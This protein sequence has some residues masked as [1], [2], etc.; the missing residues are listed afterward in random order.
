MTWIFF[1]L[2]LAFFGVPEFRWALELAFFD[3]RLTHATDKDFSAVIT[4]L[5][6]WSVPQNELR[7]LAHRAEQNR[8]AKALAFAALHLEG[9]NEAFRAADHAVKI[10]SSLYWIGAYLIPRHLDNANEAGIAA[11]I[12]IWLDRLQEFAPDNGYVYFVR[13]TYIRKQDKDFPRHITPTNVASLADKGLYLEV[14]HG[15]FTR[16]HFNDYWAQVLLLQRDVLRQEGW[17]RP[18]TFLAQHMGVPIPD[19]LHIRHYANYKVFYLASKAADERRLDDAMRE[20]HETS[21]FGQ[22]MRLEGAMLIIRLIGDATEMIAS[23]PWAESLRKAGRTKEATM[24]EQRALQHRADHLRW[25]AARRAEH[26]NHWWIRLTTRI[27]ALAVAIF[28]ALSVL[29]VFLVNLC[30]WMRPQKWGAVYQI[31][32]IGENYLCVLFFVSCVSLLVVY[33]PYASNFNYY[34]TAGDLSTGEF[35][36]PSIFPLSAAFLLETEAPPP[37]L[38]FY[39]YILWAGGGLGVLGLAGLVSA[40]R[41]RRAS[42]NQQP[43]DS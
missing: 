17:A 30:A 5:S 25:R 42:T 20:Y 23:K 27:L 11:E 22:R 32:T 41:R 43:S 28:G 10:D 34:L 29:T 21:A 18:A 40:W 19:L 26:T 6:R 7:A 4:E 37:H 39:P 36:V 8:D 38:P 33:A 1:A 35:L 3:Q 24:V 14:M 15:A 2:S 16:P 12:E 13:A 9:A 31:I